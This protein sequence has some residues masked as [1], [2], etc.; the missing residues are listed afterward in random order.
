[1]RVCGD[2][3]DMHVAAADFDDEQAVQAPEGEGA[4][5]VEEVA[6][7]M[8]AACMCR[9]WRQVVSVRLLGA[10]GI[11]RVLR[12][13]QIVHALTWCPSLSSSPWIL[14]YP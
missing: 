13:W 2:P 7:S 8:V 4:V 11:R 5:H 12:T 1:V 14:L 3:E 10:G 6:A 9:N